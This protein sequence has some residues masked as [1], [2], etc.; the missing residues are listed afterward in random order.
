[1]SLADNSV[2]ES[3]TETEMEDDDD[4]VWRDWDEKQCDY[5]LELH[6]F[7]NKAR[8]RLSE[9]WIDEEINLDDAKKLIQSI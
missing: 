9:I 2:V 8:Y 5:V 4:D 3:A 7:D 1:V 6:P